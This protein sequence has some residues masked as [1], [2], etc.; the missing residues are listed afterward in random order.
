MKHC[1]YC[2]NDIAGDA[3]HCPTC[4]KPLETSCSNCHQAIPTGIDFCPNCGAKT[5]IKIEKDKI[6]LAKDIEKEKNT[7]NFW[8]FI[9]SVVVSIVI[10][11][12]FAPASVPFWLGAYIIYQNI[13]K[14]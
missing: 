4:G 1:Y 12:V 6:K 14:R 9:L 13:K 3:K 8:L 7:T 5:Q 10:T 2:N 11:V